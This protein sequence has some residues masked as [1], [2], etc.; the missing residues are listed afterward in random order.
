MGHAIITSHLVGVVTSIRVV[1][2]HGVVLSV[3][4]IALIDLM[5]IVEVSGFSVLIFNSRNIKTFS[6]QGTI[7]SFFLKVDE[8]MN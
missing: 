3:H 7:Q 6:G 1:T 2:K 8:E 5:G 4:S